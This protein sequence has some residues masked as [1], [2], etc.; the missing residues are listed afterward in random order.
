MTLYERANEIKKATGWSQERICSETGLGLSTISRIFRVPG[1]TCNET[2]KKLLVH[3]HEKV[4]RLPFPLYLEKLFNRYDD[5]R[6]KLSKKE[7]EEMLESVERLLTSHNS[8]HAGTL[9]SCRLFWL[10]GHI[11]YDRAFYLERNVIQETCRALEAYNSALKILERQNDDRLLVQ[12]YKLQQCIVS[13]NFN[14]CKPGTRSQNPEIRRWFKE[15]NYL[16][17]VKAVIA[18][19][20]WNWIVA[21]NGLVAASILQDMRSCLYFLEAMK[22][23]HKQFSEF[24]FA[25]SKDLPALA[26]DP[27]LTWFISHLRGDSK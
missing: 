7:F 3:L 6:E 1:Y 2:S 14:S 16:N 4:V 12:K 9:E 11:H 18:V 27:D 20:S 19:D 21:R 26:K 8:L 23:V 17:L 22:Q 13:T 5:W 24:D 15:M 10:L 25:P